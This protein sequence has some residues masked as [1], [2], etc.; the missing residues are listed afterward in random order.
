LSGLENRTILEN[1]HNNRKYESLRIALKIYVISTMAFLR[2][3]LT[4]SAV[5]RSKPGDFFSEYFW[6]VCLTSL[7]V[8][9]FSGRFV[10]DGRF[11]YVFTSLM[12]SGYHD[13]VGMFRENE[14]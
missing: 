6:M 2:R 11:R 4:I 14:P 9:Y 5:I 1:F 8:K 10:E 7:G 3:H 12:C 13:V